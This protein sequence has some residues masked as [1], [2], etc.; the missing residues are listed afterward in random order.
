MR[1]ILCVLVDCLKL[2]SMAKNKERSLL[3][4]VRR[5]ESHKICEKDIRSWRKYSLGKRK[6][7]FRQ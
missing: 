1:I 5:K 3:V 7:P 4:Y 2:F 6:I